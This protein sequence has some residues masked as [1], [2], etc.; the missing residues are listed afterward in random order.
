MNLR[1]HRLKAEFDFSDFTDGVEILVSL[2]RVGSREDGGVRDVVL[3]SR[4]RVCSGKVG[5]VS[6]ESYLFAWRER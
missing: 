4:R 5:D 1:T 2:S 3:D 6:L